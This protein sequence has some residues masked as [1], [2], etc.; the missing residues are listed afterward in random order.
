MT[1]LELLTVLRSMKLALKNGTK[2]DVEELVD[3]LIRDASSE[4]KEAEK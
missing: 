4:K 1:K 2:D 3:D